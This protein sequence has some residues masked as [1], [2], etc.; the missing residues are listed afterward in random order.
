MT[1]SLFSQRGWNAFYTL[2]LTSLH[3]EMQGSV[4]LR[5]VKAVPL[6]CFY[7]SKWPSLLCPSL[8]LALF[9]I[10]RCSSFFFSAPLSRKKWLWT[11]PS[12]FLFL[13]R[14]HFIKLQSMCFVCG[15]EGMTRSMVV[16]TTVSIGGSSSLRISPLC[17]WKDVKSQLFKL[18]QAVDFF[19]FFLGGSGCVGKERFCS[20][21]FN[22]L[23]HFAVCKS[24][25]SG[26][27]QF[28]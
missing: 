12:H 24:V 1:K 3:N 6:F 28:F 11:P 22:K 23:Q 27:S 9:S 13:G 19:F 14:S 8:R 5:Q 25:C 21:F 15:E 4:V 2:S 18:S 10:S 17:P 20:V 26:Q 16:P 7:E